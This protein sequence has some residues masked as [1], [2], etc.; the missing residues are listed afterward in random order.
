MTE[1]DWFGEVDFDLLRAACEWLSE[2]KKNKRKLR[3]WACACCHRLGTFLTDKRS[4]KA[5][6]VAERL[7][8]GLADKAEVDAARKA[9]KLVPQVRVGGKGTPAE[10]AASV[11][12]ILLHPSAGEFTQTATIRA[13]IAMAESGVTTREDEER[14]QFALLRDVF[15]N[16]FQKIKF[17]KRYRTDTVLSLVRTMYDS[18][19]FSAMP[20]LADAL[21]D[22]GCDNDDILNHCRDA[23]ATHVRGCWVVDLV[24]EGS[25]A[26]LK[27]RR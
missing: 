21:Q 1:R 19:D 7:A 16:P 24:R 5:L 11:P 27:D 4:L 12:V 20:I 10:W 6:D 23:D 14:V 25:D 13:A 22:A 18:R 15:G 26:T 17:D 2:E 8:E 3:L 9:A